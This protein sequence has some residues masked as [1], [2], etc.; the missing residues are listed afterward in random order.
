ME[1]TAKQLQKMFRACGKIEKIWFRSICVA[2]ES[3][4][5]TRAKIITKEYGGFKDNKNAYV[6]YREEQSCQDAKI[7]FNQILFNQRHLRVDTCGESL[8]E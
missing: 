2:E 1:A 8:A 3:K 4:K 5:S 6:L 7:K